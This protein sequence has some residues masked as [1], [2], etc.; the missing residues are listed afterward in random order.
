MGDL[1]NMRDGNVAA[2]T[3]ENDRL[4]EKLADVRDRK[5]AAWDCTVSAAELCMEALLTMPAR[6]ASDAC[7]A[8]V[9]QVLDARDVIKGSE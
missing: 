3:S 8:L 2:L 7:R 4:R 6:E 1:I 5:A 9:A